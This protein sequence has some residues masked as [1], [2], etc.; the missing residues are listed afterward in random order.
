MYSHI[1]AEDPFLG[2]DPNNCCGEDYKPIAG[3]F[4]IVQR[5]QIAHKQTRQI[6]F[7][8]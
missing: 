8:V 4:D 5:Y 7:N 6:R 2:S 3:A 1:N